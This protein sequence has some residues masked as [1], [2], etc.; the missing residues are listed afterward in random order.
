MRP[1]RSASVTLCR[2]QVS[3]W[4]H[5][6][7]E[8]P[9]GWSW[10]S[11]S[12]SAEREWRQRGAGE[13]GWARGRMAGPWEFG[14][15]DAGGARDPTGA[16]GADVIRDS[17]PSQHTWERRP[18]ALALGAEGTSSL[19]TKGT[20]PS[21][22]FLLFQCSPAQRAPKSHLLPQSLTLKNPRHRDPPFSC[23]QRAAQRAAPE[24]CS[25]YFSSL[26]G[27]D[28]FSGLSLCHHLRPQN[29][30]EWPH[31]PPPWLLCPP[32]WQR[33]C[34]LGS[35]VTLSTGPG[36]ARRPRRDPSRGFHFSS[37]QC[38]R[39][40]RVRAQELHSSPAD[41]TETGGREVA[42]ETGLRAACRTSGPAPPGSMVP[43]L[44][45]F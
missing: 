30:L 31:A 11:P 40:L 1:A 35:C 43:G 26:P 16:L 9:R 10:S 15:L 17:V 19:I 36:R 37:S 39:G 2:C 8:V 4:Y 34:K 45:S 42:G 18:L 32:R 23:H 44:P 14:G 38:P 28:Q 25:I 7:T 24:G 6:F 13:S 20:H 27:D 3:L 33:A 5:R 29:L 22:G 41:L 12:P 21:G